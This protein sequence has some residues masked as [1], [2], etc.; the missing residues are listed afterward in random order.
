[1]SVSLVTSNRYASGYL[2]SGRV[3]VKGFD[4]QFQPPTPTVAAVYTEQYHKQTYDAVDMPFSNYVV[5]RD[6]G[7]PVTAIPVFPTMFNPILGAMV[8]RQAGI[9]GPGDLVGK[10]VG[11]SGFGFNPA[12]WLRGAL[13][14]QYDVPIEKITW[15]EGEPNSMMGVPFHRS[16]RFT[17]EKTSEN[18]MEL[19]EQG[20]L[21][22]LVMS[23]GGVEPNDKVD[24]LFPDYMAEIRKY[25]EATGV[26]PTNSVVTITEAA[27]KANPG[28]DRALVDA[29]QEAW[30]LYV[31]ESTPDAKH[32]EL[33]VDDLKSMGVFPPKQGFKANRTAINHLAHYVYEQNL[34]RKLYEPEELFSQVD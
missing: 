20:K 14:H 34:V 12:V 31:E 6:L 22:A 24:R 7:K 5:W 26:V 10:R 9:K 33:K 17:I 23:D 3:Q 1:M 18:L 29:Y 13:V 2:M 4:I 11:V 15:V 30:R 8:N 25:R 32:M 19:L 21:D 28:I 16:S 27:L